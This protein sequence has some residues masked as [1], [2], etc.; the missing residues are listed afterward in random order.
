MLLSPDS[1]SAVVVDASHALKLP[2]DEISRFDFLCMAKALEVVGSNDAPPC[3]LDPNSSAV[4]RATV[5]LNSSPRFPV[6]EIPLHCSRLVGVDL[7]LDEKTTPRQ[8][9]SHSPGARR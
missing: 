1:Q 2:H 5:V 6:S 4:D 3:V 7:R 9:R 8:A